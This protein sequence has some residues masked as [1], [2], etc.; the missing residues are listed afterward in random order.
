METLTLFDLWEP[1]PTRTER[2]GLAVCRGCGI[3][4]ELRATAPCGRVKRCVELGVDVDGLDE[5]AF[6]YTATEAGNNS[7]IRFAMSRDDACAWCESDLSRG[8]LH[9]TR[10]AYLWTSALNFFSR[11]DYIGGAAFDIS[12]FADN[13]QWDERIASLGL[14]KIG[15]DEFPALFA[16]LGITVVR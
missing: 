6:L 9:G 7:G 11:Y 4:A 16:P 13:G 2:D 12:K 3:R 8:V 14:T 1:P 5:I 10:W 15:F